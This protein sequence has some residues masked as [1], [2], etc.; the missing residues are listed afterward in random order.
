M[1]VLRRASPARDQKRNTTYSHMSL[2]GNQRE[3]LGKGENERK[4][5]KRRE[6]IL[7]DFGPRDRDDLPPCPSVP[8]HR[9]RP[10]PSRR[11]CHRPASPWH[12][13]LQALQEGR[14]SQQSLPSLTDELLQDWLHHLG[15]RHDHQLNLVDLTSCHC[16][17]A[18]QKNLDA[19]NSC[20]NMN[21]MEKHS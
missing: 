16:C 18:N 3:R 13:P 9:R 14:R 1:A 5:E 20:M 8:R 2:Q 6:R 4:G 10:S 12:G 15:N 19:S 7:M 11:R 17:A 21:K